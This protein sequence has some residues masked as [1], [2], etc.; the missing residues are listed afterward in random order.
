MRPQQRRGR[1]YFQIDRL[2]AGE[3]CPCASCVAVFPERAAAEVR[4][5]DRFKE[6]FGRISQKIGGVK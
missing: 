1:S 4:A 6:R 2:D 3:R 5:R